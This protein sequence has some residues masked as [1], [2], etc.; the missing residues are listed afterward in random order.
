MVQKMVVGGGNDDGA[1]GQCFSV[2]FSEL[3]LLCCSSADG[4]AA[5][6]S[7][8]VNQYPRKYQYYYF[9]LFHLHPS[10]FCAIS[11]QETA[12]RGCIGFDF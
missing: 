4:D 5:S 10:C 8:N 2:R 3:D 12:L 1:H 9:L 7:V 6:C 11:E